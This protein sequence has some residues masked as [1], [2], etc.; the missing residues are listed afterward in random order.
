MPKPLKTAV[1]GVGHLGQHHARIYNE[2]P[3][4]ELVAVCDSHPENGP[5]V[6]QRLGVPLIKNYLELLDKVE[7]VSIATPT[8]THLKVATPFIERGIA[9]L[10]EKPMTVTLNEAD[11]LIKLAKQNKTVIQVGHIERFNPVLLAIAPYLDN[12]RYI[13]STRV[14]VFSVQVCGCRSC[15]GCHDPR[16]RPHS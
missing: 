11:K 7:A 4:T 9:C 1:I 16:Y 2:L 6:A 15:H 14:S 5:K 12:P 8:W 10:I 3:D 13:E